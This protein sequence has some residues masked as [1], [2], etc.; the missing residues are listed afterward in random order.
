[1]SKSDQDSF[2][3]LYNHP[4]WQEMRLLVM[5]DSCFECNNCGDSEKKLN[6][7]HTYYEKGLKPWEYPQESL[8]C[9]CDKCHKMVHNQKT[10][11]NRQLG[12]MDYL[13]VERIIGYMTGIEAS[14][15]VHNVPVVLSSPDMFEGFHDYCYPNFAIEPR[16]S[17]WLSVVQYL[18]GSN[19]VAV[20]NKGMLFSADG[21]QLGISHG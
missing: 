18:N 14:A 15:K 7:H 6:V 5:E 10:Q 20:W 21:D 8:R 19:G 12:K 3:Q 4:K 13:D 2:W 1:M 11:M 17:E 9:L 16:S